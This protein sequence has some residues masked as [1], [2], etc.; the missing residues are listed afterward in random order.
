MTSTYTRSKPSPAPELSRVRRGYW[1]NRYVTDRPWTSKDGIFYAVGEHLGY[2]KWPSREIAEEKGLLWLRLGQPAA[3]WTRYLG[4]EF[5][6]E[7]AQ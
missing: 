6:P 4:A 5:F 2:F 3:Q 7:D 1:R